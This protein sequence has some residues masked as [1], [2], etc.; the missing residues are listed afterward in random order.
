MKNK[1]KFKQL[2]NQYR[3]VLYEIKY[4]DEV[5]IKANPDFEVYYR[6]YCFDNKIDLHYLNKVN[7]KKVSELMTNDVVP[8]DPEKE[9][10]IS[11][12]A[13]NIFR[14]IARKFHPD[15]V[16]E[17]ENKKEYEDVFKK[18]AGAID[19]K[20]WG[21]LFGIADEYNLDLKDYPKIHK[22]LKNE[23]KK[24]QT[25]LDKRKST[26]AWLLFS[27]DDDVDCKNKVVRSFLNHLFN[28]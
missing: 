9:N 7:S 11:Y 27:C 28:I 25:I 24:F 4:V 14:Q 20:E 15:V 13:K 3:S 22:V 19:Q 26:Y 1:F 16:S 18:A 2:L 12:D 23:I 21:T 10:N 8:K 6:E 17:K 5:L